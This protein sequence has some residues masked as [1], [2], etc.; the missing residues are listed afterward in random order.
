[1]LLLSLPSLL[2]MAHL[3]EMCAALYLR[4]ELLGTVVS[5]GLQSGFNFGRREF[6]GA[7][8]FLIVA[9]FLTTRFS[10]SGAHAWASG[11]K[12]P[13]GKME[14]LGILQKAQARWHAWQDEREQ[15]TEPACGGR[16]TDGGRKAGGSAN[17]RQGRTAEEA[18]K[19]IHLKDESDVFRGKKNGSRGGRRGRKGQGRH[20]KAPI[21]FANQEKPEKARK[22]SEIRL[23]RR[24]RI[25]NCRACSCCARAKAATSWMK[26]N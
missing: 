15:T 18:A 19:T 17:C 4:A 25:T 5:H 16:A 7:S 11:A 9:L 1:M 3:P 23:K 2:A 20:H 10:F 24:M 22:T 12:G 6:G 8:R 13:I 14:K 26:R 21:L